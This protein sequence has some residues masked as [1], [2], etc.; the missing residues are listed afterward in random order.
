MLKIEDMRIGILGGGINGLLSA[1]FLKKSGHDVTLWEAGSSV[2]GWMQSERVGGRLFEWGPHT[3][4]ADSAWFDLFSDLRLTP[5]VSRPSMPRFIWRHDRKIPVPFSPLGLAATPLFSFSA[6]M[7]LIKNLFKTVRLEEDKSIHDFFKDLLPEDIIDYAVEPFIG[8]I[9]AGDIHKLSAQTCL[10]HFWNLMREKGSLWNALRRSSGISAKPIVSFPEGLFE[11]AEALRRRLHSNIFLNTKA[12]SIQKCESKWNI[13]DQ[14]GNVLEVDHLI[15]TV[16]SFE[17]ARL[18]E[19]FIDSSDRRFL[20][21]ISYESLGVWNVVFEKSASFVSG[22][23]CLIP[24]K[25]NSSMRG[26]LW[27]SEIFEGRASR[28]E[29]VCAQYFFGNDLPQDPE[30]FLALLQRILGMSA[31]PK[32]SAY[33]IRTKSIPQLEVGHRKQIDVLVERLPEGVSLIGQYV[34]GVGL[35]AAMEMVL[36]RTRNLRPV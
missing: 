17:A 8:G 21:S 10:P 33:R 31:R 29:I 23:G 19:H 1:Y 6:K 30:R 34:D 20:Q 24:K 25:E 11:V 14:A 12:V 2:G 22:F 16:P 15:L 18:L 9:F 36:T 13:L 32:D 28:N 35:S 7:A 26:S 3:L 27:P 5:F 4:R